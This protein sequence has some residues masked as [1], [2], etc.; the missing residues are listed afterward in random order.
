MK[1]RAVVYLALLLAS[2]APSKNLA[3]V[4]TYGVASGVGSLGVHVVQP[5]DTVWKISQKYNLDL[6]GIIE[7]N[8]LSPPY[9]L[10][11]G[12]RL[13]LPAPRTYRARSTD[14]LYNVSRLF[15]TTQTELASL[16][17]LSPPYKLQQGQLLKIPSSYDAPD[18]ISMPVDT[19]T[20]APVI[21]AKIESVSLPSTLPPTVAPSEA[22]PPQPM[23]TATLQ[24]P[25]AS[26]AQ[27]VSAVKDLPVPPRAGKFLQPVNGRVIS[28]FGDKADGQ[29]NDGINIAAVKGVSVSAAENGKV[30]YVGDEIK[31]YGNMILL[32]H[33]DQYMTAY[34]HL[35]KSLVKKGD[36]VQRGQAIGTVGSTGFVDKP[37]LHFEIRKGKKAINPAGL[38]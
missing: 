29:H 4:Y 23:N 17:K 14:S 3:P 9:A 18:D 16:N 35:G 5:T 31:G 8:H 24:A 10:A 21:P 37:Q 34:A 26:R 25:A 1:K 27:T 15:N 32:R 36:V 33:K 28:N 11:T 20:S 6:R 22:M 19:V 2:C 13:S 7:A 38:I 30:V 12:S